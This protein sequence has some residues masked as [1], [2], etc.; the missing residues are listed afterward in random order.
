MTS[1]LVILIAV[2]IMAFGAW[3]E[4]RSLRKWM[5]KQQ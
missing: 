4:V 5:E 3:Y 1:D 2:W